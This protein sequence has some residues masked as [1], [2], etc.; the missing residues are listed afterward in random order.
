MDDKRI[1]KLALIVLCLNVLLV[2]IGVLV[3]WN[4]QRQAIKSALPGD[5][6]RVTAS[7]PG[8]PGQLTF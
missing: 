5:L 3:A 4:S 2:L 6:A 1:R 7:A 8:V